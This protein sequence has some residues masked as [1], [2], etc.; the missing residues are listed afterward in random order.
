VI[1]GDG[2]PQ[3]EHLE[4]L[5]GGQRLV[6][7]GVAVALRVVGSPR[8]QRGERARRQVVAGQFPEPGDLAGQD[9][10]G[11]ADGGQRLGGLPGHA[12]PGSAMTI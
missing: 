12:A 1:A 6:V 3:G 9:A 5:P 2:C 11:V 4:L 8:L 10:G 7:P